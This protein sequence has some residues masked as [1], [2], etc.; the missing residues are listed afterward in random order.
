MTLRSKFKLRLIICMSI[1]SLWFHA[2]GDFSKLQ[3]FQYFLSQSRYIKGEGWTN[4]SLLISTA[5][6]LIDGHHPFYLQNPFLLQSGKP[7]SF[8]LVFLQTSLVLLNLPSVCT[9]WN[10]G[11]PRS[12]VS[13]PHINPQIYMTVTDLNKCING[14]QATWTWLLGKISSRYRI[15]IAFFL[16][17][18]LEQ[19]H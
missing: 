15:V 10:D 16:Q 14:R 17:Q 18:W 11:I 2:V 12:R 3:D 4:Y 6:E 5:L 7:H 9:F 1:S 8:S 19:N 13:N